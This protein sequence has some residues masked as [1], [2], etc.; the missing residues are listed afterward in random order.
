MKL[1]HLDKDGTLSDGQKIE[2][3]SLENLTE[4]VQNLTLQESFKRSFKARAKLPKH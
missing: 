4:E 1:Y 2:L 3:Q